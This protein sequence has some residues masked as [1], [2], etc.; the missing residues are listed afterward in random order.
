MEC[1]LTRTPLISTDVGIASEILSSKSLYSFS[2]IGEAVP[3]TDYAF[4]K[5]ERYL[6]PMGFKEF[7]KMFEKHES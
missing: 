7:D 4:E 2:T 1:A 5:V 6:I 3:D